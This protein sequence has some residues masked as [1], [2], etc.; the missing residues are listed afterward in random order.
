MGRICRSCCW[1]KAICTTA[2]SKVAISSLFY[3]L[4]IGDKYGFEEPYD[5]TFGKPSKIV[6]IPW[7]WDLD[8]FPHFEFMSYYLD[9]HDGWCRRPRCRVPKK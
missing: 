1:R 5:I 8:D 4:R 3:R 2:H 6:E 9:P 7:M